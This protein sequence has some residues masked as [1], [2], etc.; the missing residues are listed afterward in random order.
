MPPRGGL[1]FDVRINKFQMVPADS[2]VR[3]RITNTGAMA[4]GVV[5]QGD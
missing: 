1:W 3:W 4:I 2:D 5:D